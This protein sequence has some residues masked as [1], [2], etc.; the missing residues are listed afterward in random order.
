MIYLLAAAGFV[1]MVAPP[2]KR[3]P[4]D[5]TRALSR[6]KYDMG[7]VRFCANNQTLALRTVTERCRA[8]MLR[9]HASSARLS[10]CMDVHGL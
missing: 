2:S 10:H 7:R 3:V 1:A 8:S 6:L 4:E 9:L 5:T